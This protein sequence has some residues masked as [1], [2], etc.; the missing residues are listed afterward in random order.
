MNIRAFFFLAGNKVQTSWILAASVNLRFIFATLACRSTQARGKACKGWL[1]TGLTLSLNLNLNHQGENHMKF[2]GLARIAALG[3]LV[4]LLGQVA[5]A[6]GTTMETRQG[7][8]HTGPGAVAASSSTFAVGITRDSGATYVSSAS[9]SETVEIRAVVTP[10]PA[11]VGQTG[12][13]FLV[14]RVIDNNGGHISFSMQN[15]AGV[16]LQ[17]NGTVSLLVPRVD[18]RTLDASMALTL[19]SGTLGTA[20]NHR[21][22]IGYMGSDNILRYHTSGLPLTISA[23]PTQSPSVQAKALFDSKINA[24]IVQT[25]CIACHIQGGQ[26]SSVHVFV[27]G[28]GSGALTTNYNVMVSLENRLGKAFIMDYVASPGSTHTGGQ[29]VFGAQNVA[30]FEQFMTLLSQF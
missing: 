27:P 14:D 22:F 9:V 7:S 25:N 6:Q 21:I 16:W 1:G 4:G 13:I 10:E 12:D 26:A 19:F 29:A 30:D 2:K 15:E 11:N 8:R 18:N 3:V 5:L 17:W 20:G 28:S 23:A 24:N